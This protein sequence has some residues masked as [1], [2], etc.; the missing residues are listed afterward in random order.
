MVAQGIC[1]T[2][3]Y[4]RAGVRRR[5]ARGWSGGRGPAGRLGEGGLSVAVVEQ[6][7]V[8]GECSY[9][10]CMPSKAL[11]RPGELLAEARRVPGVPVGDGLDVA[12]A[13]RAARRGHPRRRRLEP[14]A[15]A[16]GAG[17]DARP[18][19]RPARRR[20]A[21]ASGRRRA[22]GRPRGR[23]RDRQR[24][25]L[26]AARG[27]GGGATVVESRGDDRVLPPESLVVLGGGVVESSWHRRGRRS[28]CGWCCWRVR[29]GSSSARSRSRRP[30][31]R[32]RSGS[33]ASTCG[34]GSAPSRS[35]A[36][37]PTSAS[38][39]RTAT[40]SRERSCSSPSAA[41]PRRRSSGWRRSGSSRA[42]RWRSARTCARRGTTGSTRSG[43]R[44]DGPS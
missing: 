34:P 32:R 8:G 13:T 24:P 20:T 10:A 23:R 22:R 37:G 36:R 25:G 11:L 17:R 19:T 30:R 38:A 15:V 14:A 5:S 31:S 7:L 42:S 3:A 26:A 18:R 33:R 39:S 1:E 43:M 16:R 29:R 27:P 41:S 6:H 44:T 4:G 28:V 2:R 9:Y 35:R 40:A 21:R 12:A